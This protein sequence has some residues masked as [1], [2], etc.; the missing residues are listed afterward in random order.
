MSIHQLRGRWLCH[1]LAL[2][3]GRERLSLLVHCFK[4]GRKGHSARD[5]NKCTPTCYICH[6]PLVEVVDGVSVDHEC[7][8]VQEDYDPLA[9]KQ[10]FMTK[11]RPPQ[12]CTPHQL[13]VNPV[14]VTSLRRRGTSPPSPIKKPPS[15]R[16]RQAPRPR[17]QEREPLYQQGC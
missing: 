15:A 8:Y 17:R 12:E 9:F 4:C 3:R 6:K 2:R 14:R 16:R 7:L 1:E 13:E 11:Q 5:T 10:K